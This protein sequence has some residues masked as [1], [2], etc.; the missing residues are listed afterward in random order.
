[1]D[2]TTLV[3]YVGKVGIISLKGIEV[4]V[5]IADVKQSY[6]VSRFLVS[7][8]SGKGYA[9]VENVMLKEEYKLIF[10]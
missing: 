2:I 7:P 4:E 10:G 9:W 8:V 6:G 3:S 1:M 5:N